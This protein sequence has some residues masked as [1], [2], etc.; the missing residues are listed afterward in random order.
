MASAEGLIAYGMAESAGTG[1]KDCIAIGNWRGKG[2]KLALLRTTSSREL[3]EWSQENN[4]QK[5]P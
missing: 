4:L 2:T 1:A 3:S 5:R